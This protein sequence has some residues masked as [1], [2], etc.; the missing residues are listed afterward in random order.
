MELIVLGVRV[1]ESDFKLGVGDELLADGDALAQQHAWVWRIRDGLYDHVI[2]VLIKLVD[3]FVADCG[4]LKVVHPE[5]SS[6]SECFCLVDVSVA[7]LSPHEVLF[8]SY[9]HLNG[10]FCLQSLHNPLLYS[11]KG[12]P[13]SSVK[14]KNGSCS[15]GSEPA[16]DFEVAL[17]PRQVSVVELVE[18]PLVFVD[19]RLVVQLVHCLV[20]DRLPIGCDGV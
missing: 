17:A 11:F 18:S 3:A 8:V 2:Q 20:I 6:H 19:C 7:L 13:A 5:F 4:S 16:G 12:R 1:K 9:Q 10:D 15:S 14:H